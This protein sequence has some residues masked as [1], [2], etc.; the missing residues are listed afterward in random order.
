MRLSIALYRAG[1]VTKAEFAF[2]C[3]APIVWLHERHHMEGSYEDELRTISARMES[4]ERDW[5]LKDDE[6]W[7][8]K[9]APPEYQR[10]SQEYDAVL[11]RKLIE[12]FRQFAPSDLLDLLT[13]DKANFWELYE[14]GRRSVFEQGDHF[15][16]MVDLVELYE[17]EAKKCADAEAYYAA[18]AMLGSAAE[19]RILLECLR[20]AGK[21]KSILSTTPKKMRPRSSDPLEWGLSDL[22]YVADQAGWL[23][24]IDDGDI[25]HFVPGWAH[26]L[27]LTRNYLHPGRHA[28]SK[29][30]VLLGRG[31]WLD[32]QSAYAALRHSIDEAH[33]KEALQFSK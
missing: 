32:A 11:E 7:P 1:K 8:F 12:R 14:R 2:F 10:E 22:I 6:Y 28:L 23:P 31:E 19:A 4:I 27:R 9:D 33:K 29:P 26:R 24:N 15:G 25:I 3:S 17:S 18:V 21:I 5:G 13:S 20:Q 16:A 30:H